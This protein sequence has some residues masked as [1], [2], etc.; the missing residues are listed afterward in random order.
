MSIPKPVGA[1][2]FDRFCTNGAV[3]FSAAV[4]VPAATYTVGAVAAVASYAA[5]AYGTTSAI[6]A[7]PLIL[8]D[9]IQGGIEFSLANF[10]SNMA[11]A[12]VS[13]TALSAIEM[14]TSRKLLN[15]SIGQMLGRFVRS[16]NKRND[17]AILDVQEALSQSEDYSVENANLNVREQSSPFNFRPGL[18]L[19]S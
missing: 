19:S 16:H 14:F 8:S 1:K 13:T 18:E 6:I 4:I 17:S 2:A 15:L 7:M 3:T 11:A 10:D 5:D 12:A 9:S